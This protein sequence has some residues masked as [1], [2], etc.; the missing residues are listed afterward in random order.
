M[1]EKH[2]TQQKESQANTASKRRGGTRDQT[3][4]RETE[5]QNQPQET[6]N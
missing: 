1:V 6:Q 4:D 5:P 2:L 3:R